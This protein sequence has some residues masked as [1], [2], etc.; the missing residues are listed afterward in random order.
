MITTVEKIKT[1]MKK[2][3]FPYPLIC[4]P[5]NSGCFFSSYV[6]IRKSKLFI[7]ESKENYYL[8]LNIPQHK[9]YYMKRCK[10]K[11]RYFNRSIKPIASDCIIMPKMIHAKDF[12]DHVN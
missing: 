8:Y 4:T 9:Y 7:I 12:L 6:Y 2:R 3:N 10:S 1:M 5:A 11:G